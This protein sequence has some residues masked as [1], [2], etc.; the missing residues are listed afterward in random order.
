MSWQHREIPASPEEAIR[1]LR[2]RPGA[3]QLRDEERLYFGAFPTAE[4]D[5]LDP[6]GAV[7]GGES[8]QVRSEDAFDWPHWVG[9]LPYEAFRFWE[10]GG[11][12]AKDPRTAPLFERPLWRRYDAVAEAT[13]TGLLIRSTDEGAA[14]RLSECLA[15]DVGG[16][17]CIAPSLT[18]AQPPES[19]ELHEA[20][21]ERALEAISQGQLYQVNLA[22]R[23]RFRA[24]GAPLDMLSALGPLAQAPFAAAID[25]GEL[26]LV[27][28]SP[29]LFLDYLPS[30]VV[31]TR[32]IK[33]TRPRHADPV[34]DQ[35]LR[36]E[37]DAS[38]KERAELAM[39]VDIER[40]DLGR[41]SVPGSVRL[42]RAPHVTSYPTVHHREAEIEAQLRP[43][44]TREQLLLATMPSGSVTGAPKVRAMDLI[45]ASE[46]ERRGLYT[47]ALGYISPSG[48]MRLSMAI[49]VLSLHGSE[50]HYYAGGGIVA[51]S[52]PRQE[53]EETLWKAEQLSALIAMLR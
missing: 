47:G 10:R 18:W 14:R 15:S 13:P 9:A 27:S 44:V 53:L 35:E 6:F 50:A 11:G 37:L 43:E 29:E 49:R 17:P 34:V 36:N 19:G 51:D 26:Q 2:G 16:C 31:R 5:A 20:R 12:I 32:P 28:T 1:R 52:S 46:A 25:F 38:E 39:V 30:G 48:A 45:A 42:T 21:I 22:R 24:T 3:F 7:D 4:S 41:L 33:G 8:E 40:N 23:F